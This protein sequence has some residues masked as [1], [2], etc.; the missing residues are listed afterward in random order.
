MEQVSSITTIDWLII[1]VVILSTLLSLKR[2]FVKEVLSLLTW[3]IAFVV[4]VKFS[5]QMQ[6]LL[7][8]QVQNDQIRYIVAFITL[9]IA[10]LIVGALVSFL[11]GSLIQVTGLSSTDR[12][13]GML[14]GFARGSLIVIAFVALL[15]LSPAIEQSEFWKTSQ[16]I[17]QLSQLNDWTRDMV[18]KSSNLMDSSLIDRA[19]GN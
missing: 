10:T 14:F 19:L 6:V 16:L 2:G 1:A 3:V 4:A 11:L 17:P 15:S 13:L 12:V 18:G 5:N 8:E 9:F 7:V